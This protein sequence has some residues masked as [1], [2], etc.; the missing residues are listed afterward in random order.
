MATLIERFFVL[1]YVDSRQLLKFLQRRTIMRKILST[2]G[3]ITLMLVFIVGTVAAQ[4]GEDPS[5][6]PEP[7]SQPAETTSYT[8]PVVQILSAY[9]GRLSRPTLPTPTPTDTPTVDPSAEVP[10]ETPTVTPTATPMGPEEYA[11]QIAMYH[12]EGMGFGVLVKLYAMAEDAVQACLDQQANNSG[13][14]E[15]VDPTQPAC[16]AVTV[17]QLVAEFQ[18]GV[19][20][21]QL[22]KSYGKPALLGVGQV[23]KSLQNQTEEPQLTS[24]PEPGMG[25]MD[26]QT[27]NQKSNNGNGNGNGNGNTNPH[28]PPKVKTPKPHGPNK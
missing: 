18:S 10:S 12:D 3:M 8:H 26:T 4:S 2:W 27:L 13:E 16:D 5:A 17:E 7:T 9:F 15:T 28:K 11:E 23:R 22:F 25:L 1:N 21:G 24:T 14:G 19:G 6:T 20:M